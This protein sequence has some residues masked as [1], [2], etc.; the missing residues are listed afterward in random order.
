MHNWYIS[1][2]NW[3]VYATDENDTNDENVSD[4]LDD[5]DISPDAKPKQPSRKM[6]QRN[7]R[8]KSEDKPD[9]TTDSPLVN[10]NLL[11]DVYQINVSGN[12]SPQEI[13]RIIESN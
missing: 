5:D 13:L 10:R 9:T 6:T 7:K 1:Y 11:S 3:Q 2:N 8:T 4:E 12:V